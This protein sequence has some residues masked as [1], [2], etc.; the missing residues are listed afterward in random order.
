MQK[1]FSDTP[2]S[3]ESDSPATPS[4]HELLMSRRHFLYGALGVGALAVA[5]SSTIAPPYAYA[6]D[7]FSYLEVPEES[8]HT[9]DDYTEV[10]AEESV[11]L[12]AS[13]E[14]PYGTLIWSNNES[15]AACLFPTETS[16]PLTQAGV[17][18][19][20]SGQYSVLLQNAVDHASG[21]DI[22]DIRLNDKG[23]IWTEA[24]VLSGIWHIYTATFNG[25]VMGEPF[26]A[27]EGDAEWETP[28]IAAVGSFAYWQTLPVAT[29][30][31]SSEYSTLQRVGFGK[32]NIEEVYA[33]L[34]R[35]STPIYPLADSLV[36]TP[37]TDTDAV[38]HQLTL[39]DG[40]SGETKDSLVLPAS[41][42]PLE[43]GYGDAG[44]NFAFD[45]IY[46]YGG[47]IA[48]L[49]TYTPESSHDAYDYQDKT[50]FR[51]GRT[52][53]APPSW[54]QGLFIV[55]STYSV[56]GISLDNKSY[57]SL[58][59]ESGSDTYGDYLASTGALENFVTFCNVDT[60]SIYGDERRVCLVR[61]WARV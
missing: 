36:I 45:G 27:A 51:F 12:A 49:G 7:D 15:Y 30:S 11:Y 24:N 16:R 58:E 42:K 54:C 57:F 28:T 26:L 39:I 48:N 59:V 23:I 18:Y 34:G 17:L 56:C 1:D 37:R 6:D 52:P 20:S 19:L 9:L 10:P 3:Q 14:L 21:F 29:G 25:E 41:M 44:F 38:H 4:N 60:K 32:V 35:M 2:S 55:K 43:A 22:Y 53:S 47:G 8:V 46:S 40:E 61:V 13:F 31:H 33:S 50:W 5:A